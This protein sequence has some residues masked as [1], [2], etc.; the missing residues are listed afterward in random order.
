[1]S[2]QPQYSRYAAIVDQLY[3]SYASIHNPLLRIHALGHTSM[4]DSFMTLICFRRNLDPELGK[5]C[6]L[7]HDIGKYEG[8]ASHD[9]HAALGA[10]MAQSLMEETGLFTDEEIYNASHA[11]LYHS[12]KD[13]VHEPLCEA[14]KDADTM[15]SWAA[16]PN[17]TLPEAR[18]ARLIKT[19]EELGI[20]SRSDKAV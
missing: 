3:R 8:N 13:K 2:T 7:L 6:A 5:I 9:R 12:D 11:I 18:A 20:Q 15:A 16:M 14:L 17:M 1:M 19:L 4:V 10:R